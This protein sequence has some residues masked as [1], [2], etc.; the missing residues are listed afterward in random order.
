MRI[1]TL[2]MMIVAAGT[3]CFGAPPVNPPAENAA[4]PKEQRLVISAKPVGH[5][6]ELATYI[7]GGGS[8]TAEGVA[9]DKEGN[10]Y[11][12]GSTTSKD[13][14]SIL[15]NPPKPVGKKDAYLLKLDP[16]GKKVLFCQRFGGSGN[17]V[18]K[19]IAVSA[20]GTI[21]VAGDTIGGEFPANTKYPADLKTESQCMFVASFSPEGKLLQ[22]V[23]MGGTGGGVVVSRLVIDSKGQVAVGAWAACSVWP[24]TPNACEPKPN[25]LGKAALA[26]FNKDLKKLVYSTTLSAWG[27]WA[28]DAAIRDMAAMPDGSIVVAGDGMDKMPVTR[29]ALADCKDRTTGFVAR[30][31]PAGNAKN[32][33]EW[34]TYVPVS[35]SRVWSIAVDR[36][37]QLLLGGQAFMANAADFPVKPGNAEAGG[38]IQPARESNNG[39]YVMKINDRGTMMPTAGLFG[40]SQGEKVTRTIA[41]PDGDSYSIGETYSEDFPLFLPLQKTYG[42]RNQNPGGDIFI[43]RTSADGKVQFCT[44]FGGPGSETAA[45]ALFSQ[46]GELVIVGTSYGKGFPVSKDAPTPD[47][48][49]KSKAYL[50]RL[51]PAGGT[52]VG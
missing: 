52:E 25:G 11:V 7:G 48:K 18:A 50:I 3:P 35:G 30:I 36:K 4:V 51:K 13:F 33:L 32:S 21:Y 20:D 1:A 44:F 23:V 19:S 10:L 31:N 27:N 46:R 17:N 6:V 34:L 14:P 22:S 37:G 42:G 26:V 38:A 2:A 45:D 39:A 29:G 16:E 12:C 28:P 8:D 40:G 43:L 41:V 5:V 24:I 49:G 15:E 9:T 47:F